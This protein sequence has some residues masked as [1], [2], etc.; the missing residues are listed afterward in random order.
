VV[1]WWMEFGGWSKSIANPKGPLMLKGAI[2]VLLF[3][4]IM[5][6]GV[7]QSSSFIYFQF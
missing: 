6:F 1:E 5:L 4:L 2:T 7:L 3:Q